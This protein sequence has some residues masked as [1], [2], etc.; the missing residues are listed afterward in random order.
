M[1]KPPRPWIVTHHDPIEKLDDN[2]WTVSGKVPGVPIQRRM[3][4]VKQW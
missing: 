3:S 1:A 4:I 2:L